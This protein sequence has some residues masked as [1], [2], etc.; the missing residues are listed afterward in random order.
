MRLSLRWRLREKRR[1][2]GE[3]MNPASSDALPTL[4]R[5]LSMHAPQLIRE[6]SMIQKHRAREEAREVL[7]GTRERGQ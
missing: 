4:T 2:T 7:N 6:K 3:A 5:C 1:S